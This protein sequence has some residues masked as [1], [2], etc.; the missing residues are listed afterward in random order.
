MCVSEAAH[1]LQ[2]IST[3]ILG[4]SL[5]LSVFMKEDRVSQCSLDW[6]GMCPD[7]SPLTSSVPRFQTLISLYL[8]L[9][10]FLSWGI[11]GPKWWV[12]S[13]TIKRGG[14]RFGAS[15]YLSVKSS[16]LACHMKN[17]REHMLQ[18][19]PFISQRGDLRIM[20]DGIWPA[21]VY[22]MLPGFPN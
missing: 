21:C 2:L 7:P 9:Y 19:I 6:L 15:V 17:L 3:I 10:Q 14:A 13:Q 12:T 11:Q 5:S 22:E 4:E 20:A 1:L 18:L 16:P 8:V